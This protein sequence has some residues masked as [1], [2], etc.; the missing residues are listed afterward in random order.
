VGLYRRAFFFST[1][2]RYVTIV[3]NFLLISV[4]S[5]ILS[6]DEIGVSV[7]GTTIIAFAETLRDSPSSYLVQKKDLT[8]ADARTAFTIMLL[9]SL[10][11]ATILLVVAEPLGRALGQHDLAPFLWVIAA[12]LL[13]ACLERPIMALLRRDM[14]FATY[15]F[16]NITAMLTTVVLTVA[17]ALLGFSYMCFAWGLLGGTLMAALLALYIRPFFWIFRPFLSEWRR[18][19]PF[20]VYGGSSGLLAA[21]YDVVPYAIFGRSAQFAAVGYFNRAMML[22]R[23]PDKLN[24]GL[25]S[26]ALPAFSTV[27]REG[28][29]LAKAYLRALELVTVVDWP[30]RV[31]LALFAEAAVRLILGPQWIPVVPAAQIMSLA[32]LL[33][34]PQILA[35]PILVAAGRIRDTLTINLIC[36]PTSALAI[37][38]GARHGL[39]GMALAMFLIAPLQ[40]GVTLIFIRRR[41]AIHWR[42]LMAAVQK[43][44]IVSLWSAA[45]PVALV[46]ISGGRPESSLALS[47]LMCIVA[48]GGWLIG[49]RTT[50]HPIYT[51]LEHAREVLLSRISR[52]RDSRPKT[53]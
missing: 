34:T 47:A 32:F 5:R 30:L 46:L 12:C 14:E 40:T 53:R 8:R 38:L 10:L 27:V 2:E 48:A 21:V 25:I 43:S 18:V 23:I 49:I 7:I 16:I 50:R 6:P 37:A 29:N 52:L 11:I 39:D 28:G 41:V 44:L 19:L 9:V 45:G 51:E 17:L 33:S 13:P 36:L 20:N 1:A 31:L 42:D 26:L 4:I 24:A 15:A 35:Y 22:C 3:L